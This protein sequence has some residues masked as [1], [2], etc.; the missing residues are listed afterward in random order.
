[1]DKSPAS[2]VRS[3]LERII[4]MVFPPKCIFCGCV[5]EPGRKLQICTDCY[6][7]VPFYSGELVR[8]GRQR[9]GGCDC[10]V[11]IC[12]Y[13]GIIRDSLIRFKFY[14]KPGYYRTFARMLSE[15]LR[16]IG[17]VNSFDLIVSVPLHKERQRARGYNQASLIAAELSRETGIPKNTSLLSRVRSTGVQ[18]LLTGSEREKNVKGAFKVSDASKIRGRRILL[19]DDVL[20]TGSTVDECS[21]VLKEAGALTVIAAVVA[22]GRKY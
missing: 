19:I 22:T 17:D 11:C 5:L 21:R 20:T 8:S 2:A 4:E 15:R 14:S 1:M 16:E 6:R 10:A 9:G 12:R 13:T 18:S 3:C 7:K